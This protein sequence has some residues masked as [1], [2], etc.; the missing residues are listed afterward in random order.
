[1]AIPGVQLIDDELIEATLARARSSSRLRANHNFH[2]SDED[3]FHRF[4]NAF[5]RGTYV[6]PH[7]HVTPAKPENFMLLR[8][9]LACFVFDDAG[10]V[11]ERV[12]LGRGGRRGIDLAGGVWHAVL[13]VTPEAVC[14]EV[15]PGPWDPKMDKQFAPWAPREGDARAPAYLA[16]LTAM[17]S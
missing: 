3:G 5:V 14:L 15:K 1:M 16:E 7:R 11:L 9:E 17:L 4:L 12:V 10:R 2:S 6:A 8:G 13:P